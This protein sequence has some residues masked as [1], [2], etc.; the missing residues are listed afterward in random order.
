MLIYVDLEG[1]FDIRDWVFI[2]VFLGFMRMRSGVL[3]YIVR[4]PRHVC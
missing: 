3:V 1:A 4:V 2:L